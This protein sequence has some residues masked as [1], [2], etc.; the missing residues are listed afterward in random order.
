M[1]GKQEAESEL[2]Q[3]MNGLVRRNPG[4]PEFHQAVREVAEH[5]IP[6][7]LGNP[8]YRQAR[9][10]ERM[11]EPDRAIIFRVSWKD[12]KGWCGRIGDGGGSSTTPSGPT[13]VGC[14]SILRST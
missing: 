11:T 5:V 7:T 6:F 10:F 1:A 4:Q 9:V 8:R 13:K 12:D 2:N 3:F 14:A